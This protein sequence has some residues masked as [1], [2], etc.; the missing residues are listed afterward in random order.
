MRML[1]WGRE[2]NL[3]LIEENEIANYFKVSWTIR[4]QQPKLASSHLLK[5][6]IQPCMKDNENESYADS[7]LRK[8]SISGEKKSL[9]VIRPDGREVVTMMQS[10]FK[11]EAISSNWSH[12]HYT[13][14]I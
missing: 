10:F 3:W 9:K 7:Q 1:L 2:I 8:W 6:L 12:S 14:N 5:D 13:F 4:V 11:V